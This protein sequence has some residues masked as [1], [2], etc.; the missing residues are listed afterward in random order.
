DQG[1]DGAGEE[2]QDSDLRGRGGGRPAA[3][4]TGDRRSALAQNGPAGR[5]VSGRRGS[6]RSWIGRRGSGNP[7]GR[8]SAEQS[9]REDR[10]AAAEGAVQRG[11]AAA[12]SGGI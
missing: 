10:I 11:A 6:E 5:R 12:R 4:A 2:K 7:S 1:A 3:R 9:Q 8:H